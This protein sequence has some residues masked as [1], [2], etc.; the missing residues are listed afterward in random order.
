MEEVFKKKFIPKKIYYIY[1]STNK[2]NGKIYIGQR[3]INGLIEKD[4]NYIGS[5][6]HFT[7][8]VKKYGKGN[9]KKQILEI[10]SFIS[11]EYTN[12]RESY[13][14]DFYKSNNKE[15]GYNKTTGGQY[16]VGMQ[17]N[18]ETKDSIRYSLLNHP[19]KELL[20]ENNRQKHVGK[21]QSE[22]TIAK[23]IAA[24]TGKKRSDESKKKYSESKIGDKNP[25]KRL[26]VR[27]K[28]SNTL[29]NKEKVQCLYCDKKCM[30]GFAMF[31]HLKTHNK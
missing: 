3:G 13:W 20:R 31:Q 7:S 24:T 9:F 28:I 8:S 1:L 11:Q 18:Q 4:I 12:E 2:I 17:H 30:I 5:G 22:E 27:D 25:A 15:I 26:E 21:K 29:K 6:G 23:K 14:I 16:C 10:F 19:D